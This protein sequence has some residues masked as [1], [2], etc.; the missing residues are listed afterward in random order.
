M[1]CF[2]D[3][4]D[5]A[6]PGDRVTVTGIYKALP[7]RVNPRQRALKSVYKTHIMA[8]HVHKD[9][10]SELFSLSGEQQASWLIYSRSLR[11][12]VDTWWVCWAMV[13]P[14]QWQLQR[15][16]AYHHHECGSLVIQ[17]LPVCL[18]LGA[19]HACRCSGSC[20]R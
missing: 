16:L 12:L 1:L 6:K 9:G 5:V 17:R 19:C 7:V 18:K 14:M 13:D 4:I 11:A 2:E 10:Q 20:S 15:L 8:L 3:M